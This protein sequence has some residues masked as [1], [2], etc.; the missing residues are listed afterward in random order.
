VKKLLA[1]VLALLLVIPGAQ[2]F[3][4]AQL[5]GAFPKANAKVSSSISQVRLSFD[6]DLI[7]LG[8]SNRI[9]VTNSKNQRVDLN[10]PQ[11]VGNRLSVS[12][13]KLKKGKYRVSYRVISADG[14]PIEASY[15]FT[16]TK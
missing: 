8:D 3:A 7:V 11:V 12:L 2:A 9:S 16:V 4:H 14:H 1:V 15:Y 5:V 6:D 13:K 10:N